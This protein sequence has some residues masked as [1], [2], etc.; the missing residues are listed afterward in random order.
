ME[1]RIGIN[2][3]QV[4]KLNQCTKDY[5]IKLSLSFSNTITLFCSK[6]CKLHMAS[7]ATTTLH[8]QVVFFLLFWLLAP[9][10]LALNLKFYLLL[11]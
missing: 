11:D 6:S 1:N 8:Q 5:T 7:T 10:C 2:Y 9:D 4:C 3:L